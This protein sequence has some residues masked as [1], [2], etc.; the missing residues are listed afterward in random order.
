LIVAIIWQRQTEVTLSAETVVSRAIAY[1]RNETAQSPR[2]VWIKQP[3]PERPTGTP[4]DIGPQLA[5]VEDAASEPLMATSATGQELVRRLAPYGFN[6][7]APLSARHFQQWRRSTVALNEQL[8]LLDGAQRGLLKVS[9]STGTGPVRQ[10]E[11]IVR[12]G[13]YEPVGQHWMFADGFR[14]AFTSVPPPI[15]N[16]ERHPRAA[17]PETPTVAPRPAIDL[18]SSELDLRTALHDAGVPVGVGVSLTRE[19]SHVLVQ[20]DVAAPPVLAKIQAYTRQRREVR[21]ELRVKAPASL[22]DGTAESSGLHLWLNQA[23]PDSDPRERYPLTTRA[24]QAQLRTAVAV[25]AHLAR[26]YPPDVA[27]RLRS[28]Q[29]IALAALA[30]RQFAEITIAYAALEQHLAALVGTISRPSMPTDLPQNWQDR[31]IAM[32]GPLARLSDA[33]GTVLT[34]PASRPEDFASVARGQLRPVLEEVADAIA[35]TALTP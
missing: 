34:A 24:L 5:N 32:E 10:A 21:T 9:A 23:L 8:Q 28:D 18:Q 22:A 11:L 35:R 2:T 27:T 25:F 31:A 15:A 17:G 12:E 7:T 3:A 26:R 1:E 4:H 29:R 30:G 20:G 14:V 16:E 33:V 19:G 13:S 6:L